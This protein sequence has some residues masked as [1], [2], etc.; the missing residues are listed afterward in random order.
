MPTSK[1]VAGIKTT[2]LSA[3]N[4]GIAEFDPALWN[5]FSALADAEPGKPLGVPFST[6]MESYFPSLI[7]S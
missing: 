5:G 3:A 6:S 7:L 4:H 2:G 1:E